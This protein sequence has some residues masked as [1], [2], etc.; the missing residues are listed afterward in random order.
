M[1]CTEIPNH[2]IN[3]TF[4]I[5]IQ[6]LKK[7]NTLQKGKY[8]KKKLCFLHSN[9]FIRYLLLRI[10]WLFVRKRNSILWSWDFYRFLLRNYNV[11]DFSTRFLHNSKQKKNK[12]PSLNMT[13]QQRNLNRKISGRNCFDKNIAFFFFISTKFFFVS[14][15]LNSIKRNI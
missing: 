15:T 5:F 10:I 14:L 7:Q 4:F 2:S 1:W 8:S 13:H 3:C 9:N 12:I 11:R 6:S